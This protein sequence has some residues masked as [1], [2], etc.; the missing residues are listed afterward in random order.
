M[1]SFGEDLKRERE[2]R[3][4]SLEEIAEATNISRSFLEALEKNA[5]DV[6]P[7]GAY[8]RGFVRSYARHV[9]INVDETLDAYKAAVERRDAEAEE[10]AL[11]KVVRVQSPHA[12]RAAEA[13]VATSMVVATLAIGLLYWSG[14]T[15][16]STSVAPDPGAH[17]AA[18]RARFKKAGSLPS[19]PGL[20]DEEGPEGPVRSA[21]AAEPAAEEESPEVIVRLRARETTGVE[22]TCSGRVQ[23]DGE[24]WVGAERHFPCRGNILV[25]AGNGGAIDYAVGLADM[26]PLGR[27]GERVSGRNISAPPPS[28]GGDPGGR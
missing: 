17:D 2:L 7:G 13:V 22:L 26:R 24:L 20:P 18:L 19:L 25:S 21:A 8:T 16:G 28:D 15:N 23:F 5:F 1:A 4:I 27:P 11:R 9:G 3:D 14:T 10:I 12:G 6:L